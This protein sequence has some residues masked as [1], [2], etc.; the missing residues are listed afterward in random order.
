MYLR[1]K[2][3]NVSFCS[4]KSQSFRQIQLASTLEVRQGG[5]ESEPL[6]IMSVN[7]GHVEGL[8]S[9]THP[10]DGCT[11]RGDSVLSSS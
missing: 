2:W 3:Y 7:L 4:S 5:G 8:G 6:V 1:L 11:E 9:N 10:S